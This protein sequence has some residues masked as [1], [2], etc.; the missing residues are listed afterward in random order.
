MLPRVCEITNTTSPI[1]LMKQT[2]PKTIEMPPFVLV[3]YG[4]RWMYFFMTSF[5][6]ENR[7]FVGHVTLVV[8]RMNDTS[9]SHV[10]FFISHF[11]SHCIE[12]KK[13]VSCFDLQPNSSMNI[14]NH[15]NDRGNE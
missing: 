10:Y 2:F 4:I 8:L 14:Q 11:L 6:N 9:K 3:F 1:S 7:F 5:T 13:N 12:H 15:N